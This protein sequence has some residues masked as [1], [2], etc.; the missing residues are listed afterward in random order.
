MRVLALLVVAGCT[1]HIRSTPR[2]DP[3][4]MPSAVLDRQ[5]PGADTSQHPVMRSFTAGVFSTGS[6]NGEA[7][8]RVLGDIAKLALDLASL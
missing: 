8:L 6:G 2:P 7:A 5:D 4:P 1:I 3:H